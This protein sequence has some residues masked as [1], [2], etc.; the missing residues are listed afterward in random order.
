M[1]GVNEA[2]VK[3]FLEEKIRFFEILDFLAKWMEETKSLQSKAK[4]PSFLKQTK[5]LEDAL[6][7][8][9]WGLDYIRK[10]YKKI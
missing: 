10:C 4:C 7:A 9:Q 2:L 5:N 8:N 1:N 3:L 6:A